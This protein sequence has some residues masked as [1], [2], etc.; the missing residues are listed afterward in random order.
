MARLKEQESSTKGKKLHIAYNTKLSKIC[1]QKKK[2]LVV[3]HPTVESWLK[4][5]HFEEKHGDKIKA[6]KVYEQAVALLGELAN[7]ERLFVSFAKFE[8]KCKEVCQPK[9]GHIN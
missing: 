9:D 7:D 2:R 3:V 8:E 6:R 4:Y 5:A 1:A